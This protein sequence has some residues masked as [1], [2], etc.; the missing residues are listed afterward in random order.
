MPTVPVE[1]QQLDDILIGIASADA[2][3]GGLEAERMRR[4]LLEEVEQMINV[5]PLPQNVTAVDTASALNSP[6]VAECRRRD[7][8]RSIDPDDNPLRDHPITFQ[9]PNPKPREVYG[10]PREDPAV[11]RYVT[12][13]E[14]DHG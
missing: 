3:P 11:T 13:R 10:I 6:R 14:I 1:A 2:D 8:Y 12:R 9:P 5:Q 7:R 4:G